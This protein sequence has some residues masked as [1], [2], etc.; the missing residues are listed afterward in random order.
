MSTAA[1]TTSSS[2]SATNKST[3]S[4][5]VHLIPECQ[6]HM[7]SYL[8]FMDISQLCITSKPLHDLFLNNSLAHTMWMESLRRIFLTSMP[9]TIQRW[10]N[11]PKALRTMCKCLKTNK[12]YDVLEAVLAVS[13]MD[14]IVESPLNVFTPSSCMEFMSKQPQ[15]HQITGY[16]SQRRCG[17]G[18]GGAPCYW[19]SAGNSN[20]SAIE[21]MVFSLH[22]SISVIRG[23]AVTPY[24]AFFH[25]DAPVYGMMEVALQVLVINPTRSYKAFSL[26]TGREEDQDLN[27][28]NK[29]M[30]IQSDVFY[31]TEFF[32]LQNVAVRQEIFFPHPILCASGEIRLV[33]RGMYERQNVGTL[34]NNDYYGCLSHVEVFGIPFPQLM[35]EEEET[36]RSGQPVTYK[37]V[38]DEIDAIDIDS[39][40]M[41][42]VRLNK[43]SPSTSTE[44]GRS[45]IWNFIK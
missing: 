7:A 18:G 2:T 40:A 6:Y 34:D 38:T 11:I 13:T 3:R 33:F 27:Y 14:R 4:P 8:S 44:V 30:D 12:Y 28:R 42:P 10:S 22:S 29:D 45:H 39:A 5:L 19:S 26:P 21:F 35:L 24:Q 36:S 23:V 15:R 37:V 1:A 20:Q 9:A 16:Y 31:Q 25:V 17:C 43:A 41:K 32:P